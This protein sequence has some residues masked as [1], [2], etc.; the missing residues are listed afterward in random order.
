LTAATIIYVVDQFYNGSD[1]LGVAWNDPDLAV[2]WAISDP[3]L[4]ARDQNNPLWRAIEP[5]KL[6]NY[7]SNC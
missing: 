3:I 4:S 2:D 6:P 1:E 7:K 5:A